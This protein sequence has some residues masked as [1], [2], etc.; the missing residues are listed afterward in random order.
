[1]TGAH[2]RQNPA[3]PV[4]GL[5]HGIRAS[6]PQFG[7][8]PLSI[9]HRRFYDRLNHQIL[10]LCASLPRSMRT[11]GLLFFTQYAG[12]SIGSGV[13]FFQ[14]FIVPSWSIVYH[15]CQS[16]AGGLKADSGLGAAAISA[17]A[18]AMCLHSLD[19]HITD[20]QL[21]V[22][23][24]TMLIRSHAWLKMHASLDL[25]TAAVPD[26]ATVVAKCI[27]R[28]YASLVPAHH[29]EN[30]DAY[31]NR[32]RDQMATGYIVP[33]LLAHQ[34]SADPA[35]SL[36]VEQAFGSF[37]IAWRVLDDICDLAADME[38]SAPSAVYACLDDQRR[39]LWMD[40]SRDRQDRPHVLTNFIHHEDV[41]GCLVDR[42][43]RELGQ[44]AEVMAS[45][46]MP[47]MA[48]EYRSMLKPLT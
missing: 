22:T 44:A 16:D 12:L 29:P 41:C 23:P 21:A 25:L 43:C 18:M 20:G 45:V 19:D 6:E 11:D 35:F 15:L 47:G 32:F 2:H 5:S 48:E 7:T 37:G 17:H 27:D 31:C 38:A 24:L 28:Y 30:L 34:I 42:I 10:D 26:G 1:M 46:G 36:A 33:L 3:T 4:D 9:G 40:T 14:H 39:R 13:D 8:V